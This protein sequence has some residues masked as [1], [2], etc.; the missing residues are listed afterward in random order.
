M[1]FLLVAIRGAPHG[2]SWFPPAMLGR[3]LPLLARN[4][5]ADRDDEPLAALTDRE[6]QVLECM[7][8]GLDRRAIAARLC[9]SVNTVRTHVQAVLAKLQ[10]HSSLEAVALAL[11]A[12]APAERSHDA[13]AAR[14]G[15]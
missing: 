15:R 4:G 2:H 9:L 14:G 8:D 7:V 1:D 12:G 13:G 10:V 6:R 11:A 5:A 3:M